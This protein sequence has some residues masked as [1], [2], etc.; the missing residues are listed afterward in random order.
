MMSFNVY[1]T[2]FF[3]KELKKLSNKYPSIKSDFKELVDGVK[4][5]RSSSC[6]KQSF[7]CFRNHFGWMLA[8][9]KNIY[10]D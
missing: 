6:A 2:D 5:G 4:K 7:F 9:L 8:G 10:Y 3:D 1:T